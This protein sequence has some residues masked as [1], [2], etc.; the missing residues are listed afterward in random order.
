MPC[1]QDGFRK[2]FANAFLWFGTMDNEKEYFVQLKIDIARILHN[3]VSSVPRPPRPPSPAP[4]PTPDGTQN[5]KPR[6]YGDGDGDLEGGSG[7]D[8]GAMDVALVVE[9]VDEC[10]SGVADVCLEGGD[11]AG[12]SDSR[13][14]GVAQRSRTA[15]PR[16]DGR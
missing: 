10:G 6:L 3:H 14:D 4:D 16:L 13:H 5:S 7:T 2:R 11:M 12:T 15:D 9:G 1:R 8:S